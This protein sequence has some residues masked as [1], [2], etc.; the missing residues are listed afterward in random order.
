MTLCPPAHTEPQDP[1]QTF[2]RMP[3]NP[4]SSGTLGSATVNPRIY[5]AHDDFKL[6]VSIQTKKFFLN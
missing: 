4:G 1:A 5:I 6:Y 2:G 3:E